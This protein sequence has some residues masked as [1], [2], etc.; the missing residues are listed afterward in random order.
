MTW[1]GWRQGIEVTL[2]GTCDAGAHGHH[3]DRDKSVGFE[4][5]EVIR[6]EGRLY[7]G[8][9]GQFGCVIPLH[10]QCWLLVVA[11]ATEEFTIRKRN[12]TMKMN[13]YG[14]TRC[15]K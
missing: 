12:E 1:C 11:S 15:K 5:M 4:N 6:M 7:C 8:V 2:N 14:E 9:P 10:L 3:T 13:M